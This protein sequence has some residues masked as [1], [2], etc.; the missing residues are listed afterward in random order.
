MTLSRKRPLEHPLT[1]NEIA[2]RLGT[3]YQ[4]VHYAIM[5]TGVRPARRLG[6]TKLYDAADLPTIREKVEAIGRR[7]ER[8]AA[9][10]V[11]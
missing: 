5:A 10:G 11:A 2:E 1:I 8:L 7:A 4:R 9:Q 3:T 6:W